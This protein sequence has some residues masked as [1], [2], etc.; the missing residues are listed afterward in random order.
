[1]LVELR[2]AGSAGSRKGA[3]QVDSR[4]PGWCAPIVSTT[5]TVLARS[6]DTGGEVGAGSQPPSR[7]AAGSVNTTEHPEH[8]YKPLDAVMAPCSSLTTTRR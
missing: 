4:G 7:Q 1:M 8:W 5:D 6:G 3:P 2:K